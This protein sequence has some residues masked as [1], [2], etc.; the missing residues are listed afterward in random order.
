MTDPQRLTPE[1]LAEIC[2]W[3]EL[4]KKSADPTSRMIDGYVRDLLAE[5]DALRAAAERWRT[6]A[7]CVH[8]RYRL[9][10]DARV[11]YRNHRGEIVERR[12]SLSGGPPYFGTSKWHHETQWLIDVFDR[13]KKAGRTFAVRDILEWID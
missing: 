4:L 8:L 10:K 6:E 3:H 9:K 12:I 2:D 7:M 13:T 11:L 5:V 1:R